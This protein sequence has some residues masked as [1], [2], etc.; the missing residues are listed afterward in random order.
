[1]HWFVWAGEKGPEFSFAG[2]T[3]HRIIKNFIVQCGDYTKGDGTG[4]RSIYEGG[5]FD[6][7]PAGVSV[8]RNL[9]HHDR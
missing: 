5:K 6:D 1:M 2:S 8:N 4:G 7:E 9:H 3:C